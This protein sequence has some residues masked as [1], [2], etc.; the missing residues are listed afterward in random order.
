MGTDTGTKLTLPM[1]ASAPSRVWR[2]QRICIIGAAGI[3]KSGLLAN[4]PNALFINC[5]GNLGHL[6]VKQLPCRS[7]DDAREIYGLL[8]AAN[9][10]GAPFP[11]DAIVVD[12]VDKLVDY[13]EEDVVMQ[14]RK[15]F[16]KVEINNVGDVPEG[17]GWARLS[18]SVMSFLECLDSLPAAIIVITHPKV[19]KIDPAAGAKYDKETVSLF[20][21]IA[22]RLLGWSHHNLHIQSNWVGKDLSRVVRTLPDKGIEGKSHGGVVPDLWRWETRDLATEYKYL[23]SLFTD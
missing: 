22:N 17:A 21:S 5:E 6:A 8:M 14:A 4:D 11:Y 16:L 12:T 18:K 2:N 1:E 20:P 13:A 15:K 19:V 7:W 10:N 23:R 9:S 3:G